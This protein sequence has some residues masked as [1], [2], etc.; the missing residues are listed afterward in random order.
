VGLNNIRDNRAA[1]KHRTG[2]VRARR[3]NVVTSSELGRY[4]ATWRVLSLL[5]KRSRPLVRSLMVERPEPA[6]SGVR[7]AEL[8]AS[9]SLA[10]DLGLAQPEE[11]VLR[12]TVIATRLAAAAGQSDEQ[13]AAVFYVSLLAWTGCI[14]DSHELAFWFGDDRNLRADSYQLDK[15]G[16]PMLRFMIGHVARG[17]A[18][19][20]RVTMVGR[21]LTGGMGDAMRSFITHCQTTGDVAYRL[22]LHP[23]V[24][25]ALLQSF[26]RWDGKG[27]PDGL[28]GEEI[29]PVMR[30][31]H[32][33]D[34]AEVYHRSG[35]VR[36]ALAMLQ[37]R[38]GTEFDPGLVELCRSRADEIFGD[39]GSVDAWSVVLDG[40]TPLDRVIP[41][42]GLTSV[43]STFADYAD[44][45][46]P[47]FLGHSRAVAE[48]ARNA[49]VQLGMVAADV[50]LVER[51][52]LVY[53]LGTIGVS[54]GIWD[55]A[56][57]LS[58]IEWERVRT[59]P[60][61]TER[62]LCRQ[63]R[64]AEIG[65]IAAMSHERMDGSGY[66]RGLPGGAIPAPARLLA[67]ADVY[68]A[69][70]EDRPHRAALPFNE[71]AA[72][73]RADVAAGRLDA[74]MAGAVLAAAGH[75]VK[76]RAPRV[77]GLTAREAEILELLVRG[78]SHKQI[79]VEL[80]ISNRTVGSHVEHIYS[81]IGVSTRGAAAMYAM[82][83]G[84]VD[85]R[86]S[87]AEAPENIG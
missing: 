10:T 38:A 41:D 26:E 52:A 68:Q 70:A 3:E 15:I 32:I 61:L 58:A 86:V 29:E 84:L 20:H 48:L 60:Y 65:T 53:R 12:Q 33:A 76:K 30:V 39:L 25:R 43:L 9:L 13:R 46:S 40:C 85:V 24:R 50:T 37:A 67:A 44:L 55:K 28:A 73:L 71:R 87:G 51:A 64:L 31:V 80:M 23:D 49:A 35:G 78:R 69:L 2:S 16:L 81:K 7:L 8:V 21:F 42:S 5:A 18:P 27:V 79:A 82:R 47:C 62:V 11:H 66:P 45:K 22:G 72:A 14:A 56:G 63:R 34:D 17:E 77:A 1:V 19:L 74:V 54:S 4:L 57:P 83:H 6:D 36:A 59:V 75:P